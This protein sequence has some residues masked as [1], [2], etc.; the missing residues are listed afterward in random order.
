VE[1]MAKNFVRIARAIEFSGGAADRCAGAIAAGAW[2][3]CPQRS[4][5]RAYSG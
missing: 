2:A 3:A 5:R 1:A 4:L